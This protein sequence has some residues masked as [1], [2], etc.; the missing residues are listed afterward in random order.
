MVAP[1]AGCVH[2]ACIEEW[3]CQLEPTAGEMP[4]WWHLE[5][6]L[7]HPRSTTT[8]LLLINLHV[9]YRLRRLPVIPSSSLPAQSASPMSPNVVCGDVRAGVSNRFAPV[10]VVERLPASHRAEHRAAAGAQHERLVRLVLDRVP[11]H[12]RRKVAPLVPVLPRTHGNAQA[13]APGDSK[14][15]PSDANI[16]R[17]DAGLSLGGRQELGGDLEPPVAPN[18]KLN[19]SILL[20]DPGSCLTGA[21]VSRVGS[22]EIRAERHSSLEFTLE[23][24]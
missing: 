16:S 12:G 20:S 14:S 4:P 18:L 10:V 13:R 17:S 5:L 24:Q 6:G 2:P 1:R 19:G 15:S 22:S 21:Y 3:S 9:H 8:P 23:F 7:V 11:R